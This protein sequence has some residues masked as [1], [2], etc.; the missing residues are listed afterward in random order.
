MRVFVLR[1]HEE[2][3][4]GFI[5]DAFE[6]LGAALFSHVFPDDGPL[7]PVEDYDAIVVLGAK[8]S[9]YDEDTVGSWIG[10]ELDWLRGADRAGVPV[11]GICFGAQVLTAAFGGRV[12]PAPVPEIGWRTVEPVGAPVIGPGPWFQFHSDRCV[13][14]DH[15][16]LHA[17]ND[18][19]PQAFSLGRNL[20]VQF[21]PEVDG[22]Q[23]ARW[24]AYGEREVA[25]AA[26]ADPDALLDET[27][28]REEAAREQAEGLV[29]VF[30]KRA[31]V[32]PRQG[33]G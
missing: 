7:P 25:I 1:H 33:V 13:L 28:G 27:I 30:L 21:H 31:G 15:A 2:D 26:G 32:S 20:G 24:Y 22:A 18:I 17:A 11:L 23:L 3:S 10:D 8:W 5:G 19:G 4:A 6:A 9:V 16:V 12:E 14:P 29:G